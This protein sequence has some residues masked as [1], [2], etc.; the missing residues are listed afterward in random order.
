[1]ESIMEQ[2]LD[3]MM[4][5]WDEWEQHV[6]NIFKNIGYELMRI[7]IIRPMAQAGSQAAAD[8]FSQVL[9]LWGS[10]SSTQGNSYAD[11]G[12]GMMREALGNAF[13]NGVVIPMAKGY[14]VNQP[15]VFPMANGEVGL[16]GEAGPEAAVPLKRGPD[17]RLGIESYGGNGREMLGLLK[18]IAAKNTNPTVVVGIT[19]DRIEEMVFEAMRSRTGREISLDT[20]SRYG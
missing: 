15:T 2:G 10:G 17:G 8:I 1:M 7:M 6:T 19:K 18:R 16:M 3:D 14:V 13:L 5:D 11:V 9:R 4:R 20:T 12:P